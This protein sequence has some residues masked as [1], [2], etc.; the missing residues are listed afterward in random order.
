M[1]FFWRTPTKVWSNFKVTVDLQGLI[2]VQNYFY[3]KFK[4]STLSEF[5]VK[6]NPV[7]LKLKMLTTYMICVRRTRKKIQ[8]PGGI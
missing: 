5:V 8:V 1:T 6:K 4:I 3:T 2:F 7:F